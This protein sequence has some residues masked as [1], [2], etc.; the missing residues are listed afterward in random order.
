[1]LQPG[2][3]TEAPVKTQFGWHI[4]K[5]EARRKAEA[6]K[7]EDV[8]AQVF[9]IMSGEVVEK[10]VADL[11][12]NA[13]IEQYDWV[14]QGKHCRPSHRPN[15]RRSSKKRARGRHH[16]RASGFTAG[17][18]AQPT[19]SAIAGA[20]LA[21]AL[22]HALQGPRRS[23]ADRVLHRHQAAGPVYPFVHARRT[24]GMV[25]QGAVQRGRTRAGRHRRYRQSS[26]PAKLVRRR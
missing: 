12:K 13:K 6:P 7:F 5:V 19:S 11:R 23:S 15:P 1:M 16:G 26:S 9:E 14:P 2:Q 10:L 17:T 18:A 24:G 4:I 3:V 21:T 22:R 25:P 8:R 20:Q